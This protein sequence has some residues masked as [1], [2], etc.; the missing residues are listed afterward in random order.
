MNG[1][2][3]LYRLGMTPWERGHV[4]EPLARLADTLPPGRALDIGCGTGRAAVH[5]ARHDWQVT[6]LDYVPRAL[7]QAR[8]RPGA[9]AVRWVHGDITAPDTL[10][11]GDG[12]TL[13]VDLGCVHGLSTAERG[14][15]AAAMTKSAAPG[16]TLL[17]FAFAPGRRGPAP[18]GADEAEVRALFADWTLERTW[19][20]D[21]VTLKGPL[22]NAAPA[23]YLLRRQGA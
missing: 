21:D 22:R 2:P 3:L 18:R 8:K 1:Y 6:G 20:A 12:Y 13:L 11:L 7:E 14:R 15:A 23:W 17:M 19:P 10:D 9:D 16:A 5:L 4:D